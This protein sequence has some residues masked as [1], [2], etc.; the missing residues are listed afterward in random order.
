MVS[1]LSLWLPILLSAVF[2]FIVS[3]VMHMVLPHHRNDFSKVPD[4]DKLMDT[5]RALKLPP[6]DYYVPYAGS[7]DVMKSEAYQEKYRKG[8]VAFFSLLPSGQMSMTSNLIQWFFYCLLVGL[9]S[10]YVAAHTLAPGSHYLEVFRIVG[11]VAFMGYSMALFQNSIWYRKKWS[12]TLKSV[13]DGLVYALFTAGTFG[14][15][16]PA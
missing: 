15:L 2:V 12:S 3:S 1:L 7:P 16:W 10:A 8:P 13:F 9:F 5:L 4:E 11:T 6:G 14:W